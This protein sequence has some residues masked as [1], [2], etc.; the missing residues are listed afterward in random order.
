VVLSE[1]VRRSRL[2]PNTGRAATR[3]A[4]LARVQPSGHAPQTKSTASPRRI[5]GE[6]RLD[7]PMRGMFTRFD[8]VTPG[9]G[10][11]ARDL[12]TG[13]GGFLLRWFAFQCRASELT[14]G[15]EPAPHARSAWTH[16]QPGQYPEPEPKEALEANRGAGP[17]APGGRQ[18]TRTSRS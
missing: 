6:P 4:T 1:C 18:E 9:M 17:R 14:G 16:L 5:E 15:F 2:K 13:A 12:G 10:A 7:F 8:G 11:G 3:A